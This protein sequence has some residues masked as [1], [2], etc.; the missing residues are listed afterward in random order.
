MIKTGQARFYV[1]TID[2]TI[3]PAGRYQASSQKIYSRSVQPR[4]LIYLQNK[5]V[6]NFSKRYCTTRT[7]TGVPCRCQ[8]LV[9]VYCTTG[10]Y[11][12]IQQV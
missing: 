7:G 1:T 8:V 9:T 3:Y 12:V 6:S 5:P 4:S 10:I 2:S 11:D